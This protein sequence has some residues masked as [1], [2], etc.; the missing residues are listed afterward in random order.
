MEKTRMT[1]VRSY[2]G[3]FLENALQNLTQ[4]PDVA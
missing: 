3:D 1:E 4:I 2:R